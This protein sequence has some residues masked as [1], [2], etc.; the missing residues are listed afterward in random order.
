M[1]NKNTKAGITPNT[2]VPS[3]LHLYIAITV[4]GPAILMGGALR[5]LVKQTGL[6][7]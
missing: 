1:I 5:L 4:T 2:V 3:A 7:L 6:P